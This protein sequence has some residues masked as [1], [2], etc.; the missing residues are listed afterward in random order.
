M[1]SPTQTL[2]WTIRQSQGRWYEHIAEIFQDAF[3]T[4]DHLKDMSLDWEADAAD[5]PHQQ[6]L[7]MLLADFVFRLAGYR[8]VSM[9]TYMAPPYD[10]AGI[11]STKPATQRRSMN[12][13]RS[14]S[15]VLRHFE[16]L[17][18]TCAGAKGLLKDVDDVFPMAVRITME[19]FIRDKYRSDSED[20]TACLTTM[21]YTLPDNKKV[22]DTHASVRD[23]ARRGGHD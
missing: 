13:L 22:E 21:V 23:L 8:S 16:H 11:L 15:A 7:T 1:K 17:S 19:S 10:W 12:N 4:P 9:M 2:A 6:H 18:H 5:L 14:A 20:G 3:E